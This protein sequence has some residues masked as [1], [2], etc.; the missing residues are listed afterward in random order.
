MSSRG[1]GVKI[2]ALCPGMTVT[3]FHE[4]MGLD[5]GEIY[6]TKGMHKAMSP[7]EI[8]KISLDYLEKKRP[9]CIPGL[10]NRITYLLVRFLPRK[11][12]YRIIAS[13]LRK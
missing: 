6:V 7:C 9:I 10:N 5:P 3:D 11:L 1:T 2:Q 4:K 13:A 8:V 12:L